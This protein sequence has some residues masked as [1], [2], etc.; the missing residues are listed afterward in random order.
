MKKFYKKV[1]NLIA[2][3][4]NKIACRASGRGC[5]YCRSYPSLATRS[6][7]CCANSH[8]SSCTGIITLPSYCTPGF[9]IRS[10]PRPRDGTSWWTT[11]STRSC[12]ATMLWRRCGT[13]HLKQS[14]W[15]SP[16][17]NLPRWWSVA[18]ST[19]LPINTWRAATW[20]ATSLAWISI[21][22]SRCTW[23]T[24]SYSRVSSIRRT[25]LERRPT[26]S[27]LPIAHL[28][29]SAITTS[30][31]STKALIGTLGRSFLYLSPPF[32][33]SL[34]VS[35]FLFL[36]SSI[37]LSLFFLTPLVDVAIH[38]GSIHARKY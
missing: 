11:A 19:Y 7:S 17:F 22:A 37:L 24:L 4:L 10:T 16:H 1:I 36:F 32:P 38:P 33:R 5:S 31:K 29:T 23:A 18:I 2:V 30:S 27:T 20:T 15:W 28:V 3:L 14:P 13:N 21:L 9:P 8:W 6:L 35:N 34:S 26:K 12:T 25:W